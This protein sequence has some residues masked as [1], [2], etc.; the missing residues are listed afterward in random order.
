MNPVKPVWFMAF[1][2]SFCVE[3]ALGLFVDSQ[4]CLV[5]LFFCL[6]WDGVGFFCGA[7]LD[8]WEGE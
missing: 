1:L 6:R 2:N 7:M 3:W 5:G 8:G 4:C